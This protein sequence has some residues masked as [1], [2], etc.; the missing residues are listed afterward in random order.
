MHV[1]TTRNI[2]HFTTVAF[3]SSGPRRHVE[4]VRSYAPASASSMFPICRLPH[5]GRIERLSGDCFQ[6]AQLLNA[7][8]AQLVS[9]RSQTKTDQM[10]NGCSLLR[11]GFSTRAAD[12]RGPLARRL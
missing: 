7:S 5:S 12:A 8:T 3:T 1:P 9:H 4:T 6:T 2:I 10:I 11:L